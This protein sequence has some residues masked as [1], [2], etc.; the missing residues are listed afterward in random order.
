MNCCPL[1][2]YFYKR[3]TSTCSAFSG[4][5]NSARI[6]LNACQTLRRQHGGFRPIVCWKQNQATVWWWRNNT[7]QSDAD[8]LSKLIWA[9]FV[10]CWLSWPWLSSA[11]KCLLRYLSTV[12]LQ[13]IM[14]HFHSVYLIARSM[15]PVSGV[16][17]GQ[18]RR[19]EPTEQA[20]I[21]RCSWLRIWRSWVLSWF[22]KTLSGE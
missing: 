10:G 13:P 12:S 16:S 8:G 15:T 4:R 2:I 19:H 18:T 6:L 7:R 22:F 5:S 9:E 14:I 11:G 21:T 1:R 17:Y 3:V 20:G